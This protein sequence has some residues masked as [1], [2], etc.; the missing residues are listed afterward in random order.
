ML[1]RFPFRYSQGEPLLRSELTEVRRYA[2]IAAVM[3]NCILQLFRL[4]FSGPEVLK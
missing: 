4:D 2:K 1:D 3:N